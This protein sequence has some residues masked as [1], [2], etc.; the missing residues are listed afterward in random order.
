MAI[1]NVSNGDTITATWGNSVANE[2]NGLSAI[3]NYQWKT[4]YSKQDVTSDYIWTIP[5]TGTRQFRIR[6]NGTF[7]FLDSSNNEVNL[8]TGVFSISDGDLTVKSGIFPFIT[9]YFG[10]IYSE[11]NLDMDRDNGFF[12]FGRIISLMVRHYQGIMSNISYYGTEKIKFNGYNL[13][14]E[15]LQAFTN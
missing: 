11:L 4:I 1:A 3:T 2:V 7:T 15:E 5:T 8:G 9:L 14:I 12:N 13:I 6:I 10:G